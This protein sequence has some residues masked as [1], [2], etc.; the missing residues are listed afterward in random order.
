[1]KGN[2]RLIGLG[3]LGKE[4]VVPDE[5]ILQHWPT[6]EEGIRK[7]WMFTQVMEVI[8]PVAKPQQGK[9]LLC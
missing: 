6:I 3:Y 2:V 7:T 8:A 4:G 9:P 5:D 1:M